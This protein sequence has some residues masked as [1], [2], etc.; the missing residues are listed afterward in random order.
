MAFVL[1]LLLVW[2]G[3]ACI[4][5]FIADSRGRSFVGYWLFGLVAFVPAL[6][7][8]LLQPPLVT[9]AAGSMRPCP[10]CMTSIPAQATVCAQCRRDVPALSVPGRLVAEQP[11]ES[12]VLPAGE[13]TCHR[14]NCDTRGVPTEHAHCGACGHA[15]VPLTSFSGTVMSAPGVVFNPNAAPAPEPEPVAAAAL[16]PVAHPGGEQACIRIGCDL[17]GQRTKLERCPGCGH[18]TAPANV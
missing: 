5:G 15:T 6:V 9:S 10:H 16:A 3:L 14:L 4:P 11:K 1:L 8:V 18:Y 17:R 7:V 13:R 2:V 12:D